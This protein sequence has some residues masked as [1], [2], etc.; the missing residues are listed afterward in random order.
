MAQSKPKTRRG[1]AAESAAERAPRGRAFWSGTLSFGLVS[2][3]VDLYAAARRRRASLRMLS[4]D[5]H[6]LRRQ[7]RCSREGVPVPPE[8]LVRGYAL[9]SGEH[10]VVTDEELAALAPRA[11]RDIDLSRFV[12]AEQVDPMLFDRGYFL[13]PAGDTA[14]AYRLLA[15]VLAAEGRAGIATF[16]MRGKQYLVAIL[17]EGGVLRAETLRFAD[18]VRSADDVGL[19]AAKEPAATSV[20]RFARAIA[21]AA[22]DEVD[23]DEL[24]DPAASELAAL[25]ERKRR[26]GKDVVV[27]EEDVEEQGQMAEVVDL[28]AV[29]KRSLAEGK[30]TP[31]RRRTARAAKKPSKR[32]RKAG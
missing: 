25:V 8:H 4:P 7:F 2:I 20:K 11:S 9:D 23:A 28:M 17:A 21:A 24:E 30:G 1:P 22:A 31:A 32:S 3:P 29:L 19:P 16:V 14:K 6:P 15:A 5:G 18:E 12:P 13:A 10:V 26:Q 27:G